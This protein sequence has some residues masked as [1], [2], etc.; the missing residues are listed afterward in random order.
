MLKHLFNGLANKE[1]SSNILLEFIKDMDMARRS[2]KSMTND[3]P[4][5][6]EDY[7]R[8]IKSIPTKAVSGTR[9]INNKTLPNKVLNTLPTSNNQARGVSICHA[10]RSELSWQDKDPA[11]AAS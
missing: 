9:I 2:E 7:K 6:R 8:C 11:A 4:P 5:W 10:E 3:S 1:Y